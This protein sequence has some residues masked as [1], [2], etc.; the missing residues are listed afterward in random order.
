MT[1]YAQPSEY[2]MDSATRNSIPPDSTQQGGYIVSE[3]ANTRAYPAVDVQIFEDNRLVGTSRT[4]TRFVES[5][6][7]QIQR[8]KRIH[9]ARN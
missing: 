5:E 1:Q 4:N 7:K 9:G 2:R 3:G 6:Q 8:T